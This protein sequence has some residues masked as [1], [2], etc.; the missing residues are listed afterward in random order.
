MYGMCKD[1]C[2][3][4]STFKTVHNLEYKVMWLY[5]SVHFNVMIDSK[6]LNSLIDVH[7]E[8]HLAQALQASLKDPRGSEKTNRINTVTLTIV[9]TLYTS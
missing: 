9:I 6:I 8:N 4:H 1:I 3:S 7:V 2:N 5:N